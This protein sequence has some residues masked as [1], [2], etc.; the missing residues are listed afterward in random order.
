MQ[1]DRHSNVRRIE[2]SRARRMYRKV[3]YHLKN[4]DKKDQIYQLAKLESKDCKSF[5]K[6]VKK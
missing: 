4:K 5:W 2:F 1:Q 3:K 6:S